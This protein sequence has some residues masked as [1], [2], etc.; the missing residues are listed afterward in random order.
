MSAL[1]GA[2]A[3]AL[4]APALLSAQQRPRAGLWADA[5]FGLGYLRL[6]CADC[7]AANA[8]GT[9]YTV[10]IGGRPSPDVLIG[11]EG[12]VWSGTEGTLHEQVR[13]VNLVAQWYP[14]RK[15]G[16]FLRGGTGLVDG[17]VVPLDT[18]TAPAPVRGQGLGLA[19]TL[20]WDLPI[21]RRF[22]LT[23]Q[24]GDQIVALGDLA[25]PAFTADDTIAYVSRL[26]VGLTLR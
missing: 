12:Q 16:L 21:S 14:W 18:S 2:L 22:A 1:R 13:S 23:F 26:S 15:L 5:G 4:L 8:F 17:L 24:I 3:V 20:G 7:E 25:L 9:A 10:S 11:I 19:V 6:T